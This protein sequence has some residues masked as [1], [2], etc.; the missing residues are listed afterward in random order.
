VEDHQTH[1]R[2]VSMTVAML[3]SDIESLKELSAL[4]KKLNVVPYFYE[5]LKSFWTGVIERMPTLAIV[6]VKMMSHGEHNL[7]AHPLVQKAE[8]PLVFYYT[9]KTEPLLI[10]T[11]SFYHLGTIKKRE[12]RDLEGAVRTLLLRANKFLALE[13]KLYHASIDLNVEREKETRLRLEM[14]QRFKMERSQLLIKDL[15]F[16]ME[17]MSHQMDFFPILEKSFNLVEA[18]TDF[19]ILELNHNK[20]KLISP[21]LSGHKFKSIPSIWLPQKELQGI[22]LLSQNLANQVVYELFGGHIVNLLIKGEEK[23]PDLLIYIKCKDET[24]FQHFEWSLL[25]IFINSFY[26]KHLLNLKKLGSEQSF[27]LSTSEALQTL[28]S[29]RMNLKSDTSHSIGQKLVNLNFSKLIE[30]NLKNPLNIFYWDKFKNDLLLK[31]T[32][33]HRG[34]LVY[35]ENGVYDLSFIVKNDEAEILFRDLKEWI[36]RF[37]YWKYFES[38]DRGIYADLAADVSMLATSAHAYLSRF[39][40]HKFDGQKSLAQN[41]DKKK[42]D[43]QYEI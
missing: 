19:A 8:L 40:L 35:F 27:K 1:T 39:T 18:F 26:T 23:H 2:K 20:H 31:I 38:E 43:Y 17:E 3:L 29:M 32:H 36:G 30:F 42:W 21:V 41:A 7:T 22:S 15:I 28:D 37:P 5:D 13:A 6:D 16:Q 25:E 4:F 10:S 33:S 34:E 14:E 9:E 12:H 11:E 24:F